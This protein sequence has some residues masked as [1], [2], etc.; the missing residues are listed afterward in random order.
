MDITHSNQFSSDEDD[1]D[2][3]DEEDL[4]RP[5]SSQTDLDESDYIVFE[6]GDDSSRPQADSVAPAAASVTKTVHFKKSKRY[7][8]IQM[9]FCENR[10]LRYRTTWP[11]LTNVV[12]GVMEVVRYCP[13]EF[14]PFKQCYSYESVIYI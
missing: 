13:G 6:G 4:S 3:E 14:F 9:E 11:A 1:S 10:T 7:L 5:S 12:G 2:L 8:F